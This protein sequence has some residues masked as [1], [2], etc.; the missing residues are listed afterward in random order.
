MCR[1]TTGRR[2]PAWICARTEALGGTRAAVFCLCSSLARSLAP[3]HL[4]A[5]CSSRAGGRRNPAGRHPES[6]SH[7]RATQV[8]VPVRRAQQVDLCAEL[9]NQSE[10]AADCFVRPRV[11]SPGRACFVRFLWL[12]KISRREVRAHDFPL[13]IPVICILEIGNALCAL[14]VQLCPRQ[15]SSPHKSLH[16]AASATAMESPPPRCRGQGRR[17]PPPHLQL[18]TCTCRR[19]RRK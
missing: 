19:R 3:M 15:R 10:R 12:L 6:S 11:S 8:A 18:T 17:C 7:Q 5:L 13:A 14:C 16:R 9:R 1:R 2:R 4:L